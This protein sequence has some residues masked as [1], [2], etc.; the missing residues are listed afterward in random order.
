[1]IDIHAHVLPK[2]DD[3]PQSW[4]ETF[5]M[6]RIAQEHGTT[7]VAITHHILSELEYEREPEILERFAELQARMP[8]EGIDIKLHLGAEIYAQPDMTLDHQIST[9]NNMGRYCL[10]EFPMQSIPRF[11]AQRFFELLTDGVIPIL[12]H[13]ERN[14]GILRRPDIAYEYA[15]RGALLQVNAQS[16]LGRHGSRVKEIAQ[17]LMECNL[18]HIVASDAHDAVRRPLRLDDAYAVVADTWGAERADILFK[19]NPGRV[20]RGETVPAPEPI[21]I[22]EAQKGRRSILFRVREWLAQVKE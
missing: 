14:M 20:V 12:A 13:P 7:E 10:I 21:P 11:A 22:E 9:Y 18:V 6:L 17:L 15:K 8:E 4:D 1:V 19:K 16:L 3:G 5:D 2:I